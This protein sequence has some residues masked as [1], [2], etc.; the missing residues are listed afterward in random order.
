MLVFG[1]AAVG[2]ALLLRRTRRRK[3][4]SEHD[5]TIIVTTSPVRSNPSTLMLEETFRGFSHVSG[6]QSCPKIVVCD[7]YVTTKG[8]PHYKKGKITVDDAL[9]YVDFIEAMLR[10]VCSRCGRMC[11]SSATTDRAMWPF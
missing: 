2:S 5:L 1:A 9:G 4:I 11:S 6:L 3:A 7:G 10:R 8:K